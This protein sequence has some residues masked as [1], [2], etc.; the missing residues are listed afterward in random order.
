MVLKTVSWTQISRMVTITC[1]H[2]VFTSWHV[3]DVWR[4]DRVSYELNLE[5]WCAKLVTFWAR[6]WRDPTTLA[7]EARCG[8]IWAKRTLY[9]LESSGLGLSKKYRFMGS[10][11]KLGFDSSPWAKIV[12]SSS[13]FLFKTV[14]NLQKFQSN[15]T[16]RI[17]GRLISFRVQK[18]RRIFLFL[19]FATV[20]GFTMLHFASYSH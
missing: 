10:Q 20:F 13:R 17:L 12:N 9:F 2:A 14:T 6:I 11:T 4:H 15:V 1:L 18:N 7:L 16:S 5:F 19:N 8:L 3:E